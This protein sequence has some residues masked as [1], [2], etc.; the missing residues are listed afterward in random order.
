MARSCARRT[1]AGRGELRLRQRHDSR[2]SVCVGER[3]L[4]LEPRDDACAHD[5]T[6]EL[7][8]RWYFPTIG[9]S[10]HGDRVIRAAVAQAQA[11]VVLGIAGG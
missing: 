3:M 4:A 11:I 2:W 1:R 6:T 10:R 5:I 7:P 9:A 8:R